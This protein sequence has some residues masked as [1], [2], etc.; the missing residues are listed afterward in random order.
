MTGAVASA[1]GKLLL[2]GE[3]AV[4]EGARALVATVD[5]SAR[6]EIT[7][8]DS[9]DNLLLAP[10]IHPEPLPFSLSNDGVQWLAPKTENLE[11]FESVMATF[12]ATM[13]G[14]FPARPIKLSLCTREFFD[15]TGSADKTLK[16]Y[17]GAYHEVFNDTD[18]ELFM[19]DLLDWIEGGPL[20]ESDEADVFHILGAA[21]ARLHRHSRSWVVPRDF[22]RHRWEI[23]RASCRERV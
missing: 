16:I 13:N 18:Q 9:G 21:N 23:G 22:V 12:V 7:T 15:A 14:S 8:L 19:S 4:T 17:E 20:S 1:G 6:V 10:D 3:Y 5:R 2:L 11:L